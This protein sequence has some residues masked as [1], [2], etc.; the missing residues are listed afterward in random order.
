M[1]VRDALAQ[2]TARL[3]ETGIGSPEHDA[4]VLLAL[5]LGVERAALRRQES[6]DD[7]A[8]R[9]YDELLGRRCGHEPLQHILG[10]A[11][12]R[13]V[14]VSVG[15][16]VFV[17]RPETEVLAGWA[18]DVVRGLQRAGTPEPL[19][20]DL[21]TGSGVLALSLA[22]EV[23]GARVHAVELSEAAYSYAERNL[24]GSGVHLHLGDIASAL[25]EL[26][27]R[28]DVIV[29]NPPYVPLSAYEHVEAEVRDFDPPLALWSGTDGLDMIRVV[30][31]T[32]RRLLRPG[33]WVGCEHS[34]NQGDAVPRVFAGGPGWRSVRDNPDLAGRSRFVTAQRS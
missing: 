18:I 25:P 4:E 6:L 16:G 9:T 32:S 11:A 19:A 24:V 27:G 3:R 26:D 22:T 33:G 34:D 1:L 15:P 23:P 13:Y 31:A 28:V 30:E 29:S 21:C 14:E 8:T 2:A 7:V 5:V 17:P 12:F 10:R 20:V